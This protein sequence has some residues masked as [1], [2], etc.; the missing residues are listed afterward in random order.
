MAYEIPGLTIS[1]QTA[2]ANADYS[3]KQYY[4]AKLDTSGNALLP[5]AVT[6][7][8]VG[9]VQNNP[10]NSRTASVLVNGVSK[11]V[12][13]GNIAVGDNLG[14]KNDG[15]LVKVTPGTDT[16]VFLVGVALE[17]GA[18]GDKLTGLFDFA[19]A[20]RAA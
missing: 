11:Y 19:S 15:T 20:G 12:A 4:V 3:A 9:I 1:F 17:A 8:P 14:L 6:D 16:T 2:A 13:G 18:S 10:A 7:R 5:T